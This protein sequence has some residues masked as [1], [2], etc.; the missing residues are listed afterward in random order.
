MCSYSDFDSFKEGD[1]VKSDDESYTQIG[2]GIASKRFRDFTCAIA[3]K[4]YRNSGYKHSPPHKQ[5]RVCFYEFAENS[6]KAKNE[7]DNVQE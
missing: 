5:V 3:E 1:P 6:S 2:G 7:N 4:G